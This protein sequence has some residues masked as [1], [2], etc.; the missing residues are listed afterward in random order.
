[1]ARG[2]QLPL[3]NKSFVCPYRCLCPVHQHLQREKQIV[4]STQKKTAPNK[5]KSAPTPSAPI[6]DPATLAPPKPKHDILETR[7]VNLL[8]PELGLEMT[9]LVFDSILENVSWYRTMRDIH[10]YWSSMNS[11][12]HTMESNE[13]R[14]FFAASAITDDIIT[15]TFVSTTF[16]RINARERNLALAH[17]RKTGKTRKTRKDVDHS[18]NTREFLALLIIVALHKFDEGGGIEIS[19]ALLKVRRLFEEFVLPYAKQVPSPYGFRNLLLELGSTGPLQN[20]MRLN[21]KK[22][23]GLFKQFAGAN[24]ELTAR[25][26]SSIGEL[27]VL[28]DTKRTSQHTHTQNCMP[29]AT[30]HT[31]HNTA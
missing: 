17:T 29:N 19:Q 7:A 23:R 4:A 12:G 26:D 5:Q 16:I 28:G 6:S 14:G 11:V 25:D 31:P 22:L 10:M 8:E 18:M 20:T 30:Y 9:T 27:G 21:G 24:L 15:T 3:N 13:T 2:M 1:M